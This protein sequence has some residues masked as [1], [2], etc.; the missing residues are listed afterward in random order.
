MDVREERGKAI[1]EMGAVKKTAKELIWQVPA[2]S[3][4]GYYRVDLSGENPVC[5]CPD[6]ELRNQPCKH[7]YAV[8][9][10]VVREQ[11]QD[12]STT[13]TETVTVTARKQKTYPQNWPAYNKAQTTEQDKFQILLRDLCAG[14]QDP[15][16][17][18]GRPPLP[19]KDMIFSATFKIYSTFSGRRFMS[20]LRESQ[21]RGYIWKAP[22]YNSIF[23]YLESDSLTPILR[24]LV[25]QSS[26]P[27]KSVEV[28]FAVDSS[29]FTTSKFI[30]WFDVKYGKPRAE[31]EWVKAHMMCGVKTNVVTAIEIGEQFSGDSPFFPSLVQT[32]A[33]N[34][35]ISEVSADKAYDSIKCVESV[36]A[37]KGTPYIALRTTATGGV[38]GAYQQMFH[39]FQF[40]REEF[41]QHYHKRSN[42]ESTFSMVKR[43]FGDYLRSKTNVAMVNE[44]LCKVLCH[45]IVVLIHEM[46]ELGIDPV[47]W[48][49]PIE[50]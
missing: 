30:R 25:T 12:G 40:K 5:D 2:Q 21:E 31:H 32:T 4:N 15:E 20:D 28:D 14:V 22:H 46:H 47:F 41:L 36:V 27:L 11:N 19:L 49:E 10:T 3:R 23:R 6:F 38:G 1:A 50:C 16:P 17:K 34:F 9:Y 45:N 7:V 24:E 37:T 26:L 33:N 48:Q 39:Y 8:A 43:K 35:K 44:A 29:G 13:V 18:F 42:S